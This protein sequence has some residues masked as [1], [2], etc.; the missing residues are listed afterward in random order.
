MP[1][2]TFELLREEEGTGI[3]EGTVRGL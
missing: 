2:L 1:K 3:V